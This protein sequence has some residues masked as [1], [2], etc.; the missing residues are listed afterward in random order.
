M[1]TNNQS[2]VIEAMVQIAGKE[3]PYGAKVLSTVI[4]SYLEDN[5]LMPCTAD[6]KSIEA[7]IARLIMNST[8]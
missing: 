7:E 5:L 3:K 4:M 1:S 8:F 2:K 6:K